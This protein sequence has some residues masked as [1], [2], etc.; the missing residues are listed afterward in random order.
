MRHC[1]TQ[2]IQQQI[3][4]STSE[5]SVT[6]ANATLESARLSLSEYA[7][8]TFVE[9]LEQQQSEVFVAEEKQTSCRRVTS[10]SVSALPSEATSPTRSLMRTSFAL[11]KSKKEL[12]VAETKLEVLK[13]FTREKMLT[14]LR[15]DIQTA[16]AKLRS[17]QKN[18]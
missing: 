13:K 6:E 12:G 8:G 17:R 5:A 15:S 4:C 3:V 16:E 11:E 1:K 2:L 7:K 10:D 18:L 14:Q 9:Q